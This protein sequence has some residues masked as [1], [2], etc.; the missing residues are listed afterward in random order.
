MTIQQ[1]WNQ[2][3]PAVQHL[4]SKAL[5]GVRRAVKRRVSAKVRSASGGT[6]K[7]RTRGGRKLKFGSPAWQRKYKVGKF[8]KK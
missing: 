6:R 2:Q 5:G 7:K 1:G 3:T 8:A 4:L